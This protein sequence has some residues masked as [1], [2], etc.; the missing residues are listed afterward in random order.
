MA[1]PDEPFSDRI[2]LAVLA[3]ADI[4]QLT[5]AALDDQQRFHHEMDLIRPVGQIDLGPRRQNHER[6]RRSGGERWRRVIIEAAPPVLERA[7]HV[8]GQLAAHHRA[9]SDD[10][11]HEQRHALVES[12]GEAQ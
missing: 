3:A 2:V 5:L 12:L 8:C 7:D 9:V 4:V 1:W 10:L 6:L 11:P